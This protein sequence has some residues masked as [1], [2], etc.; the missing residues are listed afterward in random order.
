MVQAQVACLM[1]DGDRAARRLERAIDQLGAASMGL[2]AAV[3]RRRLGE[4]M[5]GEE[6]RALVARADTW[7]REHGVSRP[8]RMALA[9][10]PGRSVA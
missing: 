4:L 6:G 3:A 9:L 1:G 10:A 2:H 7:M 5:G 8:D